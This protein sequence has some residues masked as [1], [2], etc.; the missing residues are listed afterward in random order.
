MIELYLTCPEC[1]VEC[2]HELNQ[3][4]WKRG[5]FNSI[6]ALCSS[7]DRLTILELDKGTIIN[8]GE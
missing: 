1:N 3:W 6:S 8:L 4:Q 2:S 5:V 7:C